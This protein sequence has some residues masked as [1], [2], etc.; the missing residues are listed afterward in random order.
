VYIGDEQIEALAN[1]KS[2]DELVGD[3]L[4]LLMS[5]G[6]NILGALQSGGGNVM[7]LLKALEERGE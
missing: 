6:A 4:G 1:L 2:R 3:L 5:P 7:G